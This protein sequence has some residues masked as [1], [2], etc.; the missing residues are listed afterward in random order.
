MIVRNSV[1]PAWSSLFFSPN[2]GT[3]NFKKSSCCEIKI[4]N[5][6][7]VSQTELSVREI[8]VVDKNPIVS[9]STAAKLAIV[10]YEVKSMKVWG[11]YCNSTVTVLHGCGAQRG[12]EGYESAD[13]MIKTGLIVYSLTLNHS[14][15]QSILTSERDWRYEDFRRINYLGMK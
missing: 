14:S 10:L 5:L 4:G 11:W 15:H 12:L 1:L 3:R 6:S 8:I 9:T 2:L 7:T 13:G